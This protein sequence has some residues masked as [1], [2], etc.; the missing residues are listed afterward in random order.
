MRPWDLTRRGCDARADLGGRKE[1]AGGAHA[2]FASPEKAEA[3][4]GSSSGTILPFSFHPDL[5]PVVDPRV[6]AH[7]GINFNAAR[8]DRSLAL[9]IRDHRAHLDRTGARIHHVAARAE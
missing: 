8:L 5:E 2:S 6:L 3:L 7:P 4:A 1:P 9:D